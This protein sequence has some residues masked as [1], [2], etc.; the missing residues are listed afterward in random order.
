MPMLHSVSRHLPLSSSSRLPISTALSAAL[1]LLA[2]SGT[3]AWAGAGTSTSKSLRLQ[4]R[5]NAT[6]LQARNFEITAPVPVSVTLTCQEVG[7]DREI[8]RLNSPS[9]QHHQ[10]VLRGLKAST[11]YQCRAGL[12]SGQNA[13]IS[14][15]DSP[16]VSVITAP[17]P[18]DLKAPK[19]T[20]PTT[21]LARTGYVLYS[22]G[23][24]RYPWRVDNRYQVILDAQGNVR[25]YYAGDGGGDVD[26]TWVKPDAVLFGGYH[27]YS[28]SPTMVGLDKTVKLKDATTAVETYEQASSWNH[29]AGISEDGK[30]IFYLTYENNGTYTGFVIRQLDIA[31]KQVIWTWNS[32]VDGHDNGTLPAGSS[33]DTD[34]YHGN[35]IDDQW[36]NGRLYLYISMRNQNQVIK[37]DYE[38][39]EI[40]WHLGIDGDFQL[41]EADGTPATDSRWFFNQHDVKFYGPSLMSAHD[42]GT[43]RNQHGGTNYSRALQLDVDQKAMTARIKFEYTEPNWVEPIWGGYDVLPT[44]N[45]LLAIAH[46]WLCTGAKVASLVEI[47]STGSVVWRADFGNEKEHAY[48]AERIDGCEIFNNVNYCKQ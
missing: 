26:C 24:L 42:N 39:G 23:V 43:E 6:D 14:L 9:A 4:V 37:I 41:L 28:V 3:S 31:T 11:T 10:V 45:S 1:L 2:G 36:E 30:S 46:C 21:D 12:Q 44:G 40:L 29:D 34:P 22:Y 32:I 16:S 15:K 47:G 18:L 17:L 7:G 5:E 27:S 38:T 48:R 20:T 25:W 19:I 8:H 33:S 35:A 13:G